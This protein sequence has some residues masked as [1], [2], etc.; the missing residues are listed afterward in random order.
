MHHFKRTTIALLAAVFSLLS[1]KAQ[2]TAG[3]Q[4]LTITNLKVYEKNNKQ[5]VEWGTANA[6][7]TNYWE[8]QNSADSTT[9]TTIALV[10]GD[11]PTNPG[12]YKLVNGGK[13]VNTAKKYYRVCHINT[14]GTAQASKIIAIAK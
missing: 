10:L 3:Q 8:V 4:S 7:A 6:A 12:T 5:V 9:F 11:D 13:K 1:A 2:K 14:D